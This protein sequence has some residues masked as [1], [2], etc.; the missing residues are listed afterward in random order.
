M[1]G[2]LS[3]HLH[4]PVPPIPKPPITRMEL[5]RLEQAVLVA[6][7]VYVL[8]GE[9]L[10]KVVKFTSD[11]AVATRLLQNETL[12]GA[13]LWD[14]YGKTDDSE[15]PEMVR[16]RAHDFDCFIAQLKYRIKPSIVDQLRE[17]FS[18]VKLS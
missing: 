1:R 16:M 11:K 15:T 6:D 4:Y 3:P 12:L 13:A 9:L 10:L 8:P 2:Y 14:A 17:K 5:S 18:Q 7:D